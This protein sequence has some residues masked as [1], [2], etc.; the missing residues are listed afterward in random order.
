MFFKCH[1]VFNIEYQPSIIKLLH[2]IDYYLFEEKENDYIKITV[3]MKRISEKLKI[4]YV[5]LK[6][7]I[8]TRPN[9]DES[10]S[11]SN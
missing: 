6:D 9:G 3:A 5:M 4:S 7:D 10:S 1:K 8:E 2:F 11:E